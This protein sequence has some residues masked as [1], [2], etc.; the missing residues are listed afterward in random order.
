MLRLFVSFTQTQEGLWE[1]RPGSQHALLYPY[2]LKASGFSSTTLIERIWN[3]NSQGTAELCGLS[4]A[5][6][7]CADSEALLPAP[8]LPWSIGVLRAA[9]RGPLEH[10]LV[11]FTD[12]AGAVAL[13][14]GQKHPDL[15]F[16]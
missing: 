11:A 5:A 9:V 16:M 1:A 8:L 2:S 4:P 6:L 10:L 13:P 14:P 15:L 3:E 7:W 12:R